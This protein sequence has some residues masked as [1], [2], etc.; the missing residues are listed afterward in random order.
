MEQLSTVF[1]S[2]TYPTL[3]RSKRMP[4]AISTSS[5]FD[6]LSV[7]PDD[8]IYLKMALSRSE[9][10]YYKT[11]QAKVTIAVKLAE[12]YPSATS[13]SLLAWIFDDLQLPEKAV[14]FFEKA[15]LEVQN[16]NTKALYELYKSL[17]NS[18]LKLND[19][20][21]AKENY[22]KAFTIS[23]NS[24]RLLVNLGILA[25]QGNNWDLVQQY[26]KK[27]IE[28]NPNN[29]KAWTGLAIY[30]QNLGDYSLAIANL[31][32]ALDL[33]PSNRTALLMYTS[34]LNNL[35]AKAIERLVNYQEINFDDK[36]IS[37]VLIQKATEYNL[38]LLAQAE[39]FKLLLLE[40][41]NPSY[42]E[43]YNAIENKIKES[44]Q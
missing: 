30:H 44:N 7:S 16:E 33:N 22:H 10:Y 8:P 43:I 40:P 15:L 1:E 35:S 17:G 12:I 26:F 9:S 2:L 5:I 23:P 24:S 32:Y 29:D 25:I 42:L 20:E 36:E 31:E 4:K 39:S 14:I 19:M 18:Y 41:N 27:A 37:L 34:W 21:S 28:L 13:Y 11:S 38:L 6:A 3:N